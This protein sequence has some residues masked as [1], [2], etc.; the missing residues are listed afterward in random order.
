MDNPESVRVPVGS[1][2][3]LQHQDSPSRLGVA[4]DYDEP[5]TSQSDRPPTLPAGGASDYVSYEDYED[6]A[7][8]QPVTTTNRTTL[9]FDRK[10]LVLPEPPQ[11]KPPPFPYG[12][13]S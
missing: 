4:I 8:E 9:L 3:L 7:E 2:G 1:D 12:L 10:K 5:K 6:Y 13:L 11:F